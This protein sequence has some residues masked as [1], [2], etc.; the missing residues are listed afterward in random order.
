MVV[1]DEY[2]DPIKVVDDEVNDRMG[3]AEI[4]IG[5]NELRWREEGNK[6]NVYCAARRCVSK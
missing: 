3:I 4:S 1:D 6:G 5:I 2:V